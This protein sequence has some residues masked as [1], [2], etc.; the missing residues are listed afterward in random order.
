MRES[1]KFVSE[2][3]ERTDEAG[4]CECVVVWGVFFSIFLFRKRSQ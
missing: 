2:R 4:G 3:R 1:E